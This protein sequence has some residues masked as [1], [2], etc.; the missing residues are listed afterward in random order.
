MASKYELANID[1]IKKNHQKIHYFGLGFIQVKLSDTE[2]LH[3]YT[4]ELPKTVQQ[5]EIH[6][7]RYNFVSKI[8]FGEMLHYIYEV[9]E[10]PNGE[11]LLTKE[12]CNE[13]NKL[14]DPGISVN[15]EQVFMTKYKTSQKYYI[16]H[17][18]FHNVSC[19]DGTITHLKRTAYQKDFADVIHRKD[20]PTVC[21]FSIKV[22]EKD[23]F[24]I[25]ARNLLDYKLF[26]EL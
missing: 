22:D 23:L 6:N 19:E 14:N 8:L 18:T 1:W 4:D 26:F 12:S 3:F 21:P 7:H 25:V 5:E 11:Y 13:D 16:N 10:N 2:R 17:N 20:K 24:D 15:I 9:D